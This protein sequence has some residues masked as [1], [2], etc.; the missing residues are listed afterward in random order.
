M[1]R[2]SKKYIFSQGLLILASFFIVGHY[3]HADT[4]GQRNNFF[5]DSGYDKYFRKSMTATLRHVSGH[6]YYYVDDGYWDKLTPA[7]VTSLNNSISVAAGDFD[8]V[9][10]PKET[11]FWGLEPNPG[12]DKD[13]HITILLEE[14]VK[15]NGGYF[16]TNN[17]YPIS[18]VKDS[19]EREMIAVNIEALVVSQT[20]T[21][22]F[23][24]HEFQHL[25]GFNQK[26]LIRHVSDD[27][28]LNELRS[29]YSI[30]LVGYNDIYTDSSLQRRVASFL[31]TPSD[32]LTEWP[33]NPIDY[34]MANVFGEYLVEQ[35]GSSILSES[36][37][38][39]FVGIESIN[40][41]LMAK[42]YPEKFEDVFANWMVA[43]YLGDQSAGSKYGYARYELKSI[44]VNPQNKFYF[45]GP[46]DSYTS[47]L[48]IKNW[49]P[50]WSEFSFNIPSSKGIKLEFAPDANQ[51][52]IASYVVFYDSGL[53][54]VGRVSLVNGRGDAY[55]LNSDKKVKKI[56]LAVTDG[57]KTSGFETVDQFQNIS[58]KVS[59]VDTATAKNGILKDGALM[60]RP[61]EPPLYVIGGKYKRYLSPEVIALYGQLNPATAIEAAP[62][63]FESYASTNYVRFVD[64]KKVYAVWP[65]GTKHWLNITA[66]QWDASGR[67]WNAIFT[68]SDLELNFYKTGPDITS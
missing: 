12:I 36:L 43:A 41:Y 19:N 67:D 56:M 33:N 11:S 15:N 47:I 48:S 38:S 61:A 10:Y 62:Q 1:I 27:V 57:Q 32:S 54:E 8:N 22:N 53:P 42:G 14:L 50:A 51:N 60:K 35:Y 25:I 34:G 63:V 2:F 9:I 3:A 31:E 29:E 46:V 59:L 23:I 52:F 45:Y 20:N 39:Q 6:A 37:K 17:E 21:K 64:D 13:P 40:Q 68:I 44:R 26:E 5:V 66:Q 16:E 65:D 24:A 55:I 28:W 18:Q 7:Q 49:Q 30:S 4:V 58:V